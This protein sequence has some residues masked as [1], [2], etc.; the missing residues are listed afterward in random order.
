[1]AKGKGKNPIIS[2]GSR[3]NGS[4]NGSPLME[5]ES[6]P[7]LGTLQRKALN[8]EDFRGDETTS[9]PEM[10]IRDRDKADPESFTK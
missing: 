3:G 2:P 9:D 8:S 5:H 4:G 6:V 7:S 1:M 10:G